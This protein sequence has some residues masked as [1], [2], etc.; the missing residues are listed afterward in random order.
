MT[1]LS[2]FK[3]LHPGVFEQKDPKWGF[4]SFTKNWDMELHKV[5]EAWSL[6]IDMNDFLENLVVRF[7]D[8]SRAKMGPKW[9]FSSSIRNLC[10]IFFGFGW[11]CSVIKT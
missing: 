2:V 11:N 7:L 3:K 6:G 10:M 1:E 9:S 4:S 5:T 8:K